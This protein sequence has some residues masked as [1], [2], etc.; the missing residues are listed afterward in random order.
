[1]TG[2]PETAKNKVNRLKSPKNTSSMNTCLK[3]LPSENSQKVSRSRKET[4]VGKKSHFSKQ[5]DAKCHRKS[6]TKDTST[7]FGDSV[8]PNEEYYGF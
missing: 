1:M 6:K 8:R 4:S 5:K 7:G 2:H 3:T